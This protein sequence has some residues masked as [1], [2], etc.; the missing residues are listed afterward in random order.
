MAI[1]YPREML[2]G[3]WISE[4]AF[5]LTSTEAFNR[6]SSGAVQAT[7]VDEP[8][9]SAKFTTRRLWPADRAALRA[10][11][12]SLRGGKRFYA[13]DLE[14]RYPIAYGAAVL[15]MTRAGGGTFNGIATLTS[16][17]ATTVSMSALPASYAFKAGDQLSFPWNSGLAL[18][19][20]LEDVTANSSGVVTVTV[21]PPVRTSPAPSTGADIALV[22][23]RCI[24]TLVPGTFET[25]ANNDAPSASFEAVQVI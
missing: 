17:T 5:D 24:M 11:I 7:E 8:V 20:V 23:P 1:S 6:L 22:N 18:H 19:R 12:S 15:S 25:V 3:G 16:A 9:W 2:S 4:L 13:Q 14:R 10:W 21:D